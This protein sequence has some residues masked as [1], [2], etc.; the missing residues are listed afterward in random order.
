M[1]LQDVIYEE[2]GPLAIITLNRPRYRN[3]QSWQLLDDLDAALDHAVARDEV[4]VIIV[5]GAGDHFSS[6]H[7]L[8]TPEQEEERVRREKPGLHQEYYD[9]FR[10]YN[11]DIT[12][13]WRNLKKPTIAMVHGYCIYG[14]WMIAT[15]MDLIF[16][17]EDSQFLAGLVE[18]FTV[19][20]DVGSRQA[21]ELL[22]ESRFI[23]GHEAKDLGFINRV[24]P[25]EKLEEETF[26]YARRVAEQ[27]SYFLRM[28]KL[29]VNKTQDL[30]G[31]SNA[32]EAGFH[33]YMQ[34]SRPRAASQDRPQAAAE[35]RPGRR[36]G[37]VD[38]AVRGARGE[39]PGL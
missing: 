10:H 18:Y 22:F 21:K 35:R 36:L 14:G 33:D 25:R 5:R 30:Q 38:L 4:K 7:D 17:A 15:A 16:A 29:A 19:P 27:S 26:N 39:R 1:N 31:F 37:G 23:D 2:D 13:K 3:A 20:W 24:Y 9:S 28:A 34:V 12:H 32:V 11:F 6:G 8:G